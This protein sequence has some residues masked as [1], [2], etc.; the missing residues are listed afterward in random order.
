MN[1]V[2]LRPRISEK[3]IG[4]AE[5][6]TYVFEVPLTANKIEVA[7]AVAKNFN[8]KVAGVNMM[9]TKGK[10]VRSRQ[11]G[12]R[13]IRGRRSSVKKAMVRLQPGQKISMFDEG[14]K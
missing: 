14:G 1:P 12:G 4:M 5:T 13:Q 2:M 8:V 6:G 11:K 3:A 10:E 9:V 7:K